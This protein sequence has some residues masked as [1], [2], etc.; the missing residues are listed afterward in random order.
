MTP[1]HYQSRLEGPWHPWVKGSVNP[2]DL[3]NPKREFMGAGVYVNGCLIVSLKDEQSG[4]VWFPPKQ[5]NN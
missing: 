3:R 1:T 2:D 5:S 4:K